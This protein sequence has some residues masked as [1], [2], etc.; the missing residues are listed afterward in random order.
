MREKKIIPLR[1]PLL[2]PEGPVNQIVLR[3]PTFDEYL[4]Y[5]D[6]FSIAFTESGIPFSVEN[7]EVIKRYIGLCLVEPKDPATLVQ[8]SAVVARDVKNALLGFF[9]PDDSTSEASET[10]G[11]SSPSSGMDQTAST[12]SGS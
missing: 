10:S 8:A 3:E 11:T 12:K 2:A 5:G 9:R 1:K 6:P 4:S 7:A